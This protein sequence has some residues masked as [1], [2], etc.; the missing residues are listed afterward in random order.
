[1]SVKEFFA[2]KE[3][4]YGNI[5]WYNFFKDANFVHDNPAMDFLK[6]SEIVRTNTLGLFCFNEI[7]SRVK[8]QAKTQPNPKEL[9][10]FELLDEEF[11]K[12][13]YWEFAK[14][15]LDKEM[16]EKMLNVLRGNYE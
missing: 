11:D 13:G 4:R 14:E 7:I 1:M 9:F 16:I 5:V 2:E 10:D 15:I 6:D 12:N 3:K 8:E